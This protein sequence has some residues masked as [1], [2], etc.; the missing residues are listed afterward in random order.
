MYFK[1]LSLL[2]AFI[3]L[4]TGC[5]LKIGETPMPEQTPKV[6]L[7][8]NSCLQNLGSFMGDYFEAQVREREVS[9]FFKCLKKSFEMFQKNVRGAETE[10][11][12]GE[13]LRGF[14]QNYFLKDKV[15]T[16]ELL[17]QAM[18]IKVLFVGGDTVYFTKKELGKLIQL[19]DV[20]GQIAVDLVEHMPVL[21][22]TL[23]TASEYKNKEQLDAAIRAIYLGV[24]KLSKEFAQTQEDYKFEHLKAFV[25]E[26]Q[27][28]LKNEDFL[29][30]ASE[31][32]H[33]IGIIQTYKSVYI[34]PDSAD[35][36][37][38]QD[39]QNLFSGLGH[40]YGMLLR[41]NSLSWFEYLL[42]GD[43]FKNIVLLFDQVIS[44]LRYG[45]E[46]QPQNFLGFDKLHSLYDHFEALDM[47]PFGLRA[48][49]L[50]SVIPKLL[51]KGFGDFSLTP[52]QRYRRY[53]GLD[54][55]LLDN[56]QKEFDVWKDTQ[57]RLIGIDKAYGEDGFKY[58]K[59]YFEENPEINKTSIERIFSI[60]TLFR[61]EFAPVYIVPESLRG[62]VLRPNFDNASRLN[63]AR[64][65]I[66]FL[67]S[68]Y[69]HGHR[70]ENLVGITLREF[71]SFYNDARPL[72]VDLTIMHPTNKCV[73]KRSF[74]EG[75]LFTYSSD[76]YNTDGSEEVIYFTDGS[77][78][79]RS[80]PLL[81]FNEGMELVSILYSGGTVGYKIYNQFVEIC[82]GLDNKDVY[83]LPKVSEDCFVANAERVFLNNMLHLPQL[84]E[85]LNRDN[86]LN[87]NNWDLFFNSIFISAKDRDDSVG[88]VN[89]GVVVALTTLIHYIEM[90]MTRYDTDSNGM[91]TY[92]EVEA[93]YSVFKGVINSVLRNALGEEEFNEFSLADRKKVFFYMLD[94]GK[95]PADD[96]LDFF[97]YREDDMK[98]IRVS[99]L[100]LT[101]VF[102]SIVTMISSSPEE[103]P[104]C[105]K[106]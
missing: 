37:R 72:G 46:N 55:Y 23:D 59:D 44:H 73:G 7:S 52:E 63:I 57:V 14:L 50:K 10:Q 60:N 47:L 53:T 48:S 16:D 31:L 1:A 106:L 20:A 93:A 97:L 105:N 28:F 95:S 91:L 100:G 26:M 62:G 33:W 85:Y 34:G 78:T 103:N 30:K 2:I 40:V 51:S 104:D 96:K 80:Q 49:T 25:L 18:N 24:N 82:G 41:I 84:R 35:R 102:S 98:K 69:G 74:I 83:D 66:R 5:G 38:P 79:D 88:E 67:I 45:V 8:E 94:N 92:G 15:I 77:Y 17:Q 99:R 29:F 70:G 32:E 61:R 54:F 43:G 56:M 9:E 4:A 71:N 6:S 39:W 12:K 65:A 36:V 76:G 13:E 11:F 3:L 81:K 19:L 21:N 87:K 68:A 86:I 27:K 101:R 22:F 75:N 90:I 64:A 89:S 58:F 42:K